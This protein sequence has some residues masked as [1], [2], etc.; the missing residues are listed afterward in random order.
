MPLLEGSYRFCSSKAWST[1]LAVFGLCNALTKRCGEIG[2]APLLPHGGLR[3]I[4][5]WRKNGTLEIKLLKDIFNERGEFFNWHTYKTYVTEWR[6]CMWRPTCITLI[7]SRESPAMHHILCCFRCRRLFRGWGPAMA[8]NDLGYRSTVTDRP[9]FSD[10]RRRDWYIACFLPV[11]FLAR[12]PLQVVVVI[13]CNQAS[14]ADFGTSNN[15]ARF[16]NLYSMQGGNRHG[17]DE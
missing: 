7:D 12:L 1:H 15:I 6:F 14:G 9:R 5:A 4:E 10:T 8:R 2:P 11:N 3:R 16:C 17:Y 13:R